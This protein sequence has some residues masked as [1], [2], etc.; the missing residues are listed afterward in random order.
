MEGKATI[1]AKAFAVGGEGPLWDHRT[2]KLYWL[3]IASQQLHSHNPATGE[4][5]ITP[6]PVRISRLFL[7]GETEFAAAVPGGIARMYQENGIWKTEKLITLDADQDIVSNDGECDSQGR[8]VLGLMHKECLQGRGS[9]H[10]CGSKKSNCFAHN[11][12]VSNGIA[13]SADEKELYIVTDYPTAGL[14]HHAYDISS[15]EVG[16]LKEFIEFPHADGMCADENGNLWIV[17]VSRGV[18]VCFDPR[19]KQII[20][21]VDIPVSTTTS[22]AFG[23]VNLDTLYV[24]T[25]TWGNCVPEAPNRGSLFKVENMKVRGR[26]A[27]R[28]QW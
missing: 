14:L 23:G 21:Q 15:G 12:K 27:N 16:K 20:D 7:M 24:T 11:M 1:A 19:T 3:D 18:V 17:K 5:T 13:W 28:F 8:I 22:C 4:N 26:K 2:N 25:A 9:L 6:L 10:I